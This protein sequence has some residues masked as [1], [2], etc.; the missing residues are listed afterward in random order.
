[1]S[2]ALVHPVEQVAYQLR[3]ITYLP[4]YSHNFFVSPGY[5]KDHLKGFSETEL[6]MAKATKLVMPLWPRPKF[7]VAS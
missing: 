4:H 3:G 2:E 1:M 5:G 7:K 6:K